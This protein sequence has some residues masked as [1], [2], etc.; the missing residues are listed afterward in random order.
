MTITPMQQAAQSV[1]S[2][3]MT[4]TEAATHYNVNRNTLNSLVYRS[5][6]PAPALPPLTPRHMLPSEMRA[7]RQQGYT[8]TEIGAAAGVS[9][10]RVHQI[11]NK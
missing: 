2:G 1:L 7:L 3:I 11:C 10:Q 6:P 4:T 5:R 8:Y 9:R